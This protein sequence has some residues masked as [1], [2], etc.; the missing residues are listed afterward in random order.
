MHNSP[1]KLGL[2][3]VPIKKGDVEKFPIAFTFGSQETLKTNFL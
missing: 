1:V 2:K 3:I